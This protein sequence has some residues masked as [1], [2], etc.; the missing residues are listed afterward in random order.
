MA[1]AAETDPH[2]RAATAP[3]R[4]PWSAWKEI[5]GRVWVKTGTDNISLLAAGIAFYAFLSFVPL[6]GAMVMTYG[7]I[8][9]PASIPDHMRTIVRLVPKDAA[10]LIIDQIVSLVTTASGKKGLGLAVAMLVSLYGATRASGA[11]IMALNVV[12]EQIEKRSLLR[13]TLLS[14][15]M[16]VGAVLVAIVGLLAASALAFVGKAVDQLGTLGAIGISAATWLVAGLLASTGIAA[17]YRIAPDRHD[18]KWRWLSFGSALATLLWLLATVLFGVY[19]TTLGNYN[20]TY[21]SLSAVVVLLMWLWVSAYAILLGAEI[22][23]EAERQTARDSTAG[24]E[25]PLGRRGATVADE[26]AG[27]PGTHPSEE[28][29]REAMRGASGA[30]R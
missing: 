17:T 3:T 25:K 14:F 10:K 7:L 11:I 26:V 20:A 22:N 18:A 30:R 15:I 29:S 21:G 19:A 4:L 13:T 28:K 5:L 12:Y 2:G 1:S 16:I 23:A 8:A 9:D 24:P 27:E 6:L